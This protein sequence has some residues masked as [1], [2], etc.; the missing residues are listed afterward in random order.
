MSIMEDVKD[1]EITDDFIWVE[2]KSTGRVAYKQKGDI[3]WTHFDSKEEFIN[4]GN[5]KP[6]KVILA[7]K[8]KGKVVDKIK[9]GTTYQLKED[10]ENLYVY[11][12]NDYYKKDKKHIAPLEIFNKRLVKD[13]DF[14]TL[15][16][17]LWEECVKF[18][19]GDIPDSH[20]NSEV[21]LL[22][23]NH[24]KKDDE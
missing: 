7:S 18:N 14:M 3:L 16:R 22:V 1:Y 21:A 9:V 12:Y 5:I 8:P 11:C 4:R 6:V 10:N 17:H 13:M 15:E 20:T 24:L 2:Y 19:S 23:Y